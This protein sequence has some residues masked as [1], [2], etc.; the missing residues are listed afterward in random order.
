MKH[1][2]Q[3]VCSEKTADKKYLQINQREDVWV[4][5]AKPIKR[6]KNSKYTLIIFFREE[7]VRLYVEVEVKSGKAKV[8]KRPE[9]LPSLLSHGPIMPLTTVSLH[10]ESSFPTA[11]KISPSCYSAVTA[12]NI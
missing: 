5:K 8:A 6:K 1:L 12:L 4:R 2:G 10:A 9:P 7:L 11:H 3:V